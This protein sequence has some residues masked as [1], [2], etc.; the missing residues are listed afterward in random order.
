MTCPRRLLKKLTGN[1]GEVQWGWNFAYK[2]SPYHDSYT[3]IISLIYVTLYIPLQKLGYDSSNWDRAW[4]VH[5]YNNAIYFKWGNKTCSWWMPWDWK[6][7]RHQIMY[8]DGLKTPPGNSWDEKDGRLVETH[9]YK[10]TL[11]NGTVQNCIAT[12]YTEE[13][14]WR[15]KWF[16]WLPWPKD[17]RRT[18][19]VNFD[20]EV[21]EKSGTWK[22][23]VTGCG[24]DV[25]PG[26]KMLDTLRR[27]EKERKF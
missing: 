16:T 5:W 18:I 25:L 8:S 7:V 13:R 11:K 6:C 14:E 26:E 21:G 10:Y 1:L 17:I 23:G 12:V 22:G 19:S 24:H 4:G 15:W 9:P 20:N 27:M 2:V 3:L